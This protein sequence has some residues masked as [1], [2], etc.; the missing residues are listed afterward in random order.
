MTKFVSPL[1]RH[2]LKNER[3]LFVYQFH[4][5]GVLPSLFLP[6]VFYVDPILGQKFLPWI[7]FP[8]LLTG[9][10]MTWKTRFK[11]HLIPISDIFTSYGFSYFVWGMDMMEWIPDFFRFWI[12]LKAFMLFLITF[13]RILIS[14]TFLKPELLMLLIPLSLTHLGN[15]NKVS[16]FMIVSWTGTLFTLSHDSYWIF[17]SKPCMVSRFMIQS[18]PFLFFI[19]SNFC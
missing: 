6:F 1:A 14:K 2:L 15:Q 3:E 12:H 11:P 9:F 16:S 7:V 10:Y 18:L 17:S 13:Q 8:M 19:V 5:L 4:A